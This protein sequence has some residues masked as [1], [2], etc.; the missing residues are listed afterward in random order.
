MKRTNRQAE[1]ELQQ[2]LAVVL[3]ELKKPSLTEQFLSQFLTQT[4]VQALAKRLAILKKLHQNY[5]YAQ[6]Q[7]ELA[8]SSATISLVAQIKDS[9]IGEQMIESLSVH[10]WA[11]KTARTI[12]SWFAN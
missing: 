11:T 5:S 2:D 3:T 12:R 10:D 9:E 7:K 4:E 8:V 6:I 1:Q